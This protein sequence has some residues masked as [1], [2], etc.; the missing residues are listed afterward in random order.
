MDSGL[1]DVDEAERYEEHEVE[2]LQPKQASWGSDSRRYDHGRA[3]CAAVGA[4]R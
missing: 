4:C 2:D 3:G 1:L